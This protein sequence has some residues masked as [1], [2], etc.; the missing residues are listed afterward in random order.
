ME[1]FIKKMIKLK[2][3]YLLFCQVISE[4]TLVVDIDGKGKFKNEKGARL[5]LE[6]TI[7]KLNK[8]GKTILVGPVLS[9]MKMYLFTCQCFNSKQ[10]I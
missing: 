1:N 7:N 6:N 4:G 10:T 2:M 3:L 9:M 8:F 5:G